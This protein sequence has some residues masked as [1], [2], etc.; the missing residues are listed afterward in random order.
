MDVDIA[1]Y[2]RVMAQAADLDCIF[3]IADLLTILNQE[4]AANAFR[5]IKE[6]CVSGDLIKIKRGFYVTPAATL[7]AISN[8]MYPNSYVS[9]GT[10]LAARAIIGSVPARRIQAVKIGASRIFTCT[11]GTIE[12]LSIHPK[13]FFGFERREDSFWAT[14]EKAYLDVCYFYYKRKRF[15][16]DPESDVDRT[17]LNSAIIKEYLQKYDDR[18]ITF[19]RKRFLA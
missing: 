11:L 5:L 1:H 8:R 15:S 7:V 19:F 4:S 3:T 17:M 13:L 6:L 9:T 14:P 12:F 10:V 18:F 2:R 16:F